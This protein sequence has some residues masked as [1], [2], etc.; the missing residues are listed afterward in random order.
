MAGTVKAVEVCSGKA[1]IGTARLGGRVELG[2]GKMG[3]GVARRLWSVG[4]WSVAVSRGGR[5]ELWSGKMGYGEAVQVCWG[6]VS[7]V[8]A[9]QGMA[10]ELS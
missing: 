10:V 7:W 5:V 8:T 2:L 6:L 4:V 1:W 3:F 9:Y